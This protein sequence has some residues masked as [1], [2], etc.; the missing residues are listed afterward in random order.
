MASELKLH[1]AMTSTIIQPRSLPESFSNV[2]KTV[3][4]ITIENVEY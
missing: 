1:Q 2:M 4:A 3:C